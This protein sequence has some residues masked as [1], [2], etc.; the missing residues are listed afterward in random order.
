MDE[1]LPALCRKFRDA[2]EPARIELRALVVAQ[3]VLARDAVA[4]AEAQQAALE[5]DQLLVDV[6]ELLD[7]R[8]DTGLVQPQRLHLD[9]DFVLQ[10]LVFAL[11]RRRQRLVL[12]L[13]G[14]VLL[15]Q[16]AQLLVVV[17]D[18]VEGLDHLR[19][20]LGLDGGER[21][22]VFELVV[23]HVAFGGGLSRILFGFGSG[24]GRGA[25]RGRRRR[26]GGRRDMRRCR[27]GGD[28]RTIVGA[29]RQRL[30]VGPDRGR[31]QRVHVVL[32]VGTGVGRFQ[33]DD[34]AKE[35]L[36]LVEFVAPDDDGLEGQRAF[37]EACDHRLAA[38]LDAFCDRDFA[39]A[40]QQ[41]DG[42][43]LAQIHADG[44]VG[45]LAGLGFLDLGDGLLRDLDQFVVGLVL[46]L[47]LGLF[48]AVGILGLGDVDAHVGE[49]RHDVLDLLRRRGVGGQDFIE[50]I[51]GHE[52]A[53]LGLLDHLLDG[54][55]RQVEQR[56][57]RVRG[58]LLG[59]VRCLVVF[60]LVLDLQR[61]CLGGHSVLSK[62]AHA[63]ALPLPALNCVSLA[64]DDVSSKRHHALIFF[65]A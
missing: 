17:G 49:H 39:L 65:R 59:G 60:F 16:A 25:E 51:E 58:I 9:D 7:Q 62:R 42:A 38:G 8:I 50:L 24:G 15:L 43:H 45:A 44:I 53:L 48:V 63:G 61:L 18:L 32:G 26:R 27:V 2:V 21:H 35:D 5:R 23:V 47:F 55:I 54:G 52:A 19:L 29:G 41:L 22:L 37:A 56:R 1:I 64:P 12:Q 4:V 40:R 3:K 30:A 11:L 28:R 46:G 34:V 31:Q 13:V 33:I 20:Q 57:R 14:N 6:V 10:L 36:S